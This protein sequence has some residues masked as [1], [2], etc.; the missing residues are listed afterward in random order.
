MTRFILTLVASLS[1][2]VA[3]SQTKTFI[4][5]P[6]IE[7]TGEADTLVTPNEIYIKMIISEKD[8][9]DKISI[10]ELESKMI[11]A[12]KELSINIEK[13][14]E[15]S[16]ILSNYTFYLLKQKDIMKSKEYILK[17]TD[18]ATASKVFVKL[19]DIGISN[20]GIDRVEHTEFKK[21][22]NIC[23]TKAIMAARAKA[24][25]MTKPLNQSVGRAIY[26]SDITPGYEGNPGQA[27]RIRIRGYSSYAINGK[28]E[29]PKIEFQ[30]IQVSSNVGVKFV[31]E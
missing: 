21:L 19:E 11:N 12:F 27:S 7:V 18:A 23:R 3:Q 9:K 25:A 10:E 5:Q 8:S 4:D 1:L 17:V 31:L 26:I 16:D 2:S 28:Y 15:M 22:E 30:K 13:D 6:Y 24:S 20:A 29:A 14:L